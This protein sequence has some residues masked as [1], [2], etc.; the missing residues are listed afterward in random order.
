MRKLSPNDCWN[1]CSQTLT[2]WEW[3]RMRPFASPNKTW[4]QKTPKV[5]RQCP[6]RSNI[7]H[8]PVTRLLHLDSFWG[9]EA[10]QAILDEISCFISYNKDL[11]QPH[12]GFPKG[13]PDKVF[14]IW[15]FSGPFSPPHV[16]Y[17]KTLGK[18]ILKGSHGSR[19][20]SSHRVMMPFAV[21]AFWQG[22]FFNRGKTYVSCS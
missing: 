21:A 16:Q 6:S 2:C 8:V 1:K 13:T 10:V 3:F 14:G 15:F 22:A 20:F 7:K 18:V 12:S 5:P 9:W 19:H 11:K 4:S 17:G